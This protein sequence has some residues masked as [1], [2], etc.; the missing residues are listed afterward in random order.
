MRPVFIDLDGTL[1]DGP[2]SESMFFDYLTRRKI[3]KF[4]HY[5]SFFFF[6]LRWFW[7][8]GKKAIRMNK[9]YLVGMRRADVDVYADSFAKKVLLELVRPEMWRR[10]ERH[11][12]RGDQI[13]LLAEAPDFLLRSLAR[14]MDVPYWRGTICAYVGNRYLGGLP[15][16]FMDGARKVEQAEMIAKRM[17]FEL[18]HCYAY[19]DAK[20]DIPLLE[21][22]GKPIAVFPDRKLEK[23]AEKNGWS[24]ID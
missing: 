15:E 10:I 13:V 6:S 9:A 12:A 3:I 17:G 2:D 1:I 18:K 23:V 8:Y 5:L 19:A 20:T 7:R 14:R 21:A 24:I 4:D 22:V 16:L 11:K